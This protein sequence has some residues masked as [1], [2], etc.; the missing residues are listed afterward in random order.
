MSSLGMSVV[1]RVPNAD[2]FP[3]L[4]AL[5]HIAAVDDSVTVDEKQM[6]MEYADTWELD[7]SSHGKIRKILR[8]GTNLSLDAL[9]AEFSETGTRFLLL[10][11]L[12]RLSYADGTYADAERK[13][14]ARIAQRLGMTEEQFLEVEEWVERGRAWEPGEEKGPD[15][16]DLEER[17]NREDSNDHDLADIRTGDADLS[18]INQS[19]VGE[20]VSAE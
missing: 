2:R 19:G 4:K 6:V 9:V 14:I 17:L 11:E 15:A 5:A 16:S 10:Q 18:D 7:D 20:D 8:S 1:A 12:V 13:E 3:F